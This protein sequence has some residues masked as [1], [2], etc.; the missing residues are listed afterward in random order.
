MSISDPK[1]EVHVRLPPSENHKPNESP[2]TVPFVIDDLLEHEVGACG[3]WQWSLVCLAIFSTAATSNFPNFFDT[4]PRHRCYMGESWEIEFTQNALTFD[5]IIELTGGNMAQMHKQSEQWTGCQQFVADWERGPLIP[6]NQ[7]DFTKLPV[8]RLTNRTVPCKRGYVFAFDEHQYQGGIVA[9]MNLVCDRHWML[10][11]GTSLFMIG[12]VLGYVI[13]GIWAGRFGRKNALLFFSVL[14]LL[15]VWLCSVAY[16]FWLF[17]VLRFLVAIGSYAKLSAFNLIILEITVAKYRSLFNALTMLG[18]NCVGRLILVAV[19]YEFPNWRA[20]NFGASLHCAL[21]FTYFCLVPES[22][23]WLLTQDRMLD[24]IR[25]LQS[26]RHINHLHKPGHVPSELLER[27]CHQEQF[28]HT[29]A[30]TN[31]QCSESCEKQIRNPPAKSVREQLIQL[32]SDWKLIRITALSVLI[33]NAYS[34]NFMGLILYTRMIRQSVFLVSLLN[35]LIT[36][37]GTLVAILCYRL[38]RH[39]RFPLAAVLFLC[40][41]ALMTGGLYTYIVKPERDWVMTIALEIGL[42]FYAATQCLFFIYIP[43]LYPPAVRAQG[44]GLASGFGRSGS[45]GSTYANDMDYTMGHAVPMLLY[46]SVTFA[47]GLAV[48]CLPDTTGE[49]RD[50]INPTSY[51]S[52]YKTETRDW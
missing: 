29:Q 28:E 21:T 30:R 36:I 38:S 1:T 18:F 43:E 15:S 51:S 4:Q 46:A 13:C 27:L 25:V 26:G 44:F 2:R 24:A 11:V 23:R 39:R 17:S 45:A 37:P 31:Q 47:E 35:S 41:T 8:K 40:G 3:L 34:F 5:Q 10:P 6:L 42:M 12:M 48:L 9:E 16:N 14:E 33:F 49:E 19:A 20:L 52:D 50:E 32:L 7:T 22:P